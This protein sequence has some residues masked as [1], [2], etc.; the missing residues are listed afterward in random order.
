MLIMCQIL[1]SACCSP[2]EVKVVERYLI[3]HKKARSGL[4]YIGVY[5]DFRRCLVI[6]LTKLLTGVLVLFFFSAWIG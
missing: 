5:E 1:P 3:C 2:F 4:Y 6:G